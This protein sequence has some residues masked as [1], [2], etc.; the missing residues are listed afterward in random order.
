MKKE[1]HQRAT[2]TAAACRAELEALYARSNGRLHPR[3]VVAFAR[4]PKTALHSQFLW[5]DTEAAKHYR[6]SQARELISAYVEVLPGV[7]FET[8]VFVSLPSDR[9]TRGGYRKMTE[10]MGDASL[11]AE[12]LAAAFRELEALRIRYARLEELAEVFAALDAAKK[13]SR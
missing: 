6:L 3:D 4:D 10:V 13:K 2:G 7:K 9:E 11:R 8:R 12:F 1:R 5:D